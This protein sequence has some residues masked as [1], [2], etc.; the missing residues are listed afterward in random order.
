MRVLGLTAIGDHSTPPLAPG[1]MRAPC[2]VGSV[3]MFSC[4]IMASEKRI[5]LPVARSWTY[6]WPVLPAW[7][8]TST[9]LPEASFACVRM[10]GLTASRS[11]TSGATY[12]ECHLYLPSSRTTATLESGEGL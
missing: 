1:S 10:G 2:G 5:S 8:T 12:C 4:G 11:H 7:I 9:T 3:H 6:T